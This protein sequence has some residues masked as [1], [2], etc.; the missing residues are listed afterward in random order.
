MKKKEINA[1][2]Q[3]KEVNYDL[4][5]EYE[6]L[7]KIENKKVKVSIFTMI[8][9]LFKSIFKDKSFLITML[10]SVLG[11]L[12]ISIAML[13][14]QNSAS[15]VILYNYY[16]LINSFVIMTISTLKMIGFFF[17]L[18]KD[19]KTINILISQPIKRSTIF[20][21]TFLTIFFI[22]AI[23][24]ITG[25]LL[26]NLVLTIG[27]FSLNLVMLRIT[28]VYLIYTLVV[29][30][31]LEA[32]IIYLVIL[33]G[34]NVATIVSTLIVSFGII[35]ALPYS[36]LQAN[37]Q[38]RI[39]IVNFQN[40][41]SPTG[42]SVSTTRIASV[43]DIHDAVRFAQLVD[44]GQIRYPNLM[45]FLTY[46]ILEGINGDPIAT[47]NFESTLSILHRRN[48]WNELGLLLQDNVNV[49]FSAP[50]MQIPNIPAWTGWESGATF[51]PRHFDLNFAQPFISPSMLEERYQE[52]VNQNLHIN[53]TLGDRAFA[54]FVH[55]FNYI[56]NI[57]FNNKRDALIESMPDYDDEDIDG[58]L[59]DDFY[60]AFATRNL[61][62]TLLNAT[63]R[64]SRAAS[65]PNWEDPGEI[66]PLSSGLVANILETRFAPQNNTLMLAFDSVSNLAN[67]DIN[68]GGIG[69][70]VMMVA[71]ML[72]NFIVERV[73]LFGILTNG[74]VNSSHSSWHEY[75][76]A[77]NI[78]N[79]SL[80]FNPLAAVMSLYTEFSGLSWND[81][82]F[83][84][85]TFA[86]NLN[87]QRNMFLTYS[88]FSLQ[89]DEDGSVNRYT[90]NN[91]TPVLYFLLIQVVIFIGTF[92]L[93]ILK[94]RRMD[95]N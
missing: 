38:S 20:H 15:K 43:T 10:L 66:L 41:A 95:F 1:L 30:I 5:K 42:Q 68:D 58:R 89:L 33:L 17:Q 51:E 16:V 25:F 82:W 37:E 85:N 23:S 49:R 36:F 48:Y 83:D 74:T 91:Y 45:Q 63:G 73:T 81:I 24:S 64:V 22:F 7:G 2:E 3:Q 79:I 53:G 94:F 50:V 29:F 18:K 12:V 84:H 67:R 88:S 21:A 76:S 57:F 93:S 69:S 80:F 70:R 56:E 77:R 39:L 4:E 59:N 54:E 9:Y 90:Y 44:N 11:P 26:V 72:E 8:Y 62:G 47:D 35:A 71:R 27:S 55:F 34:L 86:V 40:G 13:F 60:S 52:L 61:Y 78:Y 31:L 14:A 6:K 65:V 28:F 75:I 46:S 19:D 87:E 92:T 32:F